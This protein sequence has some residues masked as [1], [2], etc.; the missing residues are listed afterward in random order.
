MDSLELLTS[1]IWQLAPLTKRGRE[2]VLRPAGDT[3]RAALVA[4]W[5]VRQLGEADPFAL[6][7]RLKDHLMH[8]RLVSASPERMPLEFMD[9]CLVVTATQVI[10]VHGSDETWAL[11]QLGD[12][13]VG[14]YPAPRRRARPLPE[15]DAEAL[16]WL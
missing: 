1:P 16:S 6:V 13:I 14:T 3:L 5:R 12:V 15:G 9:R 11:S 7:L 10:A 4:G 8:G 2:A